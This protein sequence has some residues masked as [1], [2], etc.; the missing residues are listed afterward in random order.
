MLV[1]NR[2]FEPT[3]RLFGASIGG[4]WLRRNFAEIFGV[5]KL[6]SLGYMALFAWSC[7]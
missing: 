2:Q 4:G 5:R 7:I 6:E 3:P 1:E